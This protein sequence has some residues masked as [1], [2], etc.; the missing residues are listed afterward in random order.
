MISELIVLHHRQGVYKSESWKNRSSFNMF[1]CEFSWWWP[2][3]A[4]SYSIILV[5]YIEHYEVRFFFKVIIE[6]VSEISKRKSRN[7]RYISDVVILTD[8]FGYEV[9]FSRFKIFALLCS[10]I[11]NSKSSTQH[12]LA[13]D[14]EYFITYRVSFLH[15]LFILQ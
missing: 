7:S 4:I 11:Q 6:C 9:T 3:Y 14:C 5:T 8:L 12:H 2:T 10:R 15:S 13:K 1:L